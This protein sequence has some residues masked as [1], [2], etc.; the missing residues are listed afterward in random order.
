MANYYKSSSQTKDKSRIRWVQYKDWATQQDLYAA[1]VTM[2]DRTDTEPDVTKK[3]VLGVVCMDLNM[4]VKPTTLK[5][6]TT[7]YSNFMRQI[8]NTART[9]VGALFMNYEFVPEESRY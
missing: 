9:L 3:A 6:D 1:C 7:G 8:S 2:L 4:I 5:T